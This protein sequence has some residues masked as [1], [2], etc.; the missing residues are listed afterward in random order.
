[1]K[2]LLRDGLRKLVQPTSRHPAGSRD[3]LVIAVAAHKGGVGKTTTS[4]HLA[5]ALARFHGLR[6]LLLDLDPQAHVA[7]SLAAHVPTEGI[8]L[9][10]V[11]EDE[12]AADVLD[13]V[14]RTRIEGLDVTVRDP[15]LAATEARI[16]SRIGKETI[17]RDALRVARTWYDVIVLDCPPAISNLTLNALV[18]C[19]RVLIPCEPGPLAAQ[20]VDSLVETIATVAA[21][22]N[23]T[24]DVLGILPT[25]VDGRASTVNQPILDALH[26]RY[27]DAILPVRIGVATAIPRAQ[28]AGTDIFDVEPSSRPATQYKELATWLVANSS[29]RSRASAP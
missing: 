5:T 8:P 2:N 22:L 4:V 29:L 28:D 21:R 14:Q 20:G 10:R 3:A 25:R 7:R 16:A 23:P 17:L 1:M 11:L 19:D 26:A 12:R 27:G 13:A 24:I 6:V 9:S 18:A 15:D